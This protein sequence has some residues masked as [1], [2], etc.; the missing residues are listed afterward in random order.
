MS[1]GPSGGSWLSRETRLLLLTVAVCAIALVGLA[2]LR[3]P[4]RPVVDTA[5]PPLERLAAR[6]SYDELAA[7][8]RRVEGL[9][10]PNLVVLR[11]LPPPHTEP[12]A[13]RDALAEAGSPSRVRHVAAL[14]IGA[15]AALAV[16]E[17]GARIDGV[18]GASGPA[19][20]ADVVA[21]DPVRRIAYVRVAGA[22]VRP[23][24]TVGLA[25]LR[26]PLYVV[27]VEGTEAGVT[28]RP[29]FLG[30]GDRFDSARW[31][32]PLLP[33]G[34]SV[35]APGALLFTL[36]GEFI[37]TAVIENGSPAV[38]EA[39][40]VVAAAEA[41]GSRAS[42]TPAD[43]GI[44]VQRLSPSLAAAL[45]VSQGVVVSDVDPQGSAAGLLEVEDVVTTV[46][47]RPIGDPDTFLLNLASRA[48]GD[49]AVLTVT[50][51]GQ[52]QVVTVPL[53]SAEAEPA[54][55]RPF[56]FSIERG[57]GT[58][59][60]SAP[61]VSGLVAGDVVTRA[62][63]IIAPT[64]AQLRRLLAENTPSGFLTLVVR[65]DG[66]QRLVAVPIEKGRDGTRP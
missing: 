13:I 51:G 41:I 11:T 37:G 1:V 61:D 21:A 54:P 28:L 31:S 56:A 39:S 20:S 27:V 53:G 29:V 60:E 22:P 44:T 5:T 34:G 52:P 32:R 23:L 48:V 47:G 40:D 6:A 10:S 15:D 12:R 65:R 7:D 66:R 33:L 16:I 4:E 18:A 2:R 26:M 8:I 42:S 25:A 24:P 63:T 62:G 30:R 19:M 17:A 3:F 55:P 45:D 9:I 59:V 14:R 35:I 38:V 50:R 57:L 58:R 46:D 36:A 49:R 43:P 64:P